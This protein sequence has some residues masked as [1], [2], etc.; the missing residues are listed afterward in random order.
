MVSRSGEGELVFHAVGV[1]AGTWQEPP[2]TGTPPRF[3]EGPGERLTDTK[4][5]ACPDRARIPLVAWE[6]FVRLRF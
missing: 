3:G 5:P 6:E 2:M 4:A 1:R